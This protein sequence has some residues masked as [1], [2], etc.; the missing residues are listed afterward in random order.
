MPSPLAN[1]EFITFDLETTGFSAQ[2]CEI[3][4]FGAVRFAADGTEIGRFQQLVDPGCEV[5]YRASQVNGITTDML[6]GQPTL[7]EVLP[8]FLSFLASRPAVMLAHNAAF[9]IRFLDAGIART[10]CRGVPKHPIV[11]TVPLSRARL[12]GLRNHKLADVGAHLKIGSSTAH[13]ALADSLLLKSVFL[14][15]TSRSPAVLSLDELFQLSSPF[16]L[17]TRCLEQ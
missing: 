11:D 17:E 14:R 10:Q 6:C 8:E 5:P 15:L 7:E 16:R 3:I 12:P 2:S 13:R 4:E 9:D 1:L